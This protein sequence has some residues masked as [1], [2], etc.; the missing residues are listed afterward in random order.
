MD[1]DDSQSIDTVSVA[2][3]DPLRMTYPRIKNNLVDCED[4]DYADE[5][6]YDHGGEFQLSNDFPSFLDELMRCREEDDDD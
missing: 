4:Y 2:E 5:L 1:V 6:V 3:F